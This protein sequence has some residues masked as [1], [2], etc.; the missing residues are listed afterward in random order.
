MRD[1]A[2]LNGP[3]REFIVFSMLEVTDKSLRARRS[4]PCCRHRDGPDQSAVSS[5]GPQSHHWSDSS[6]P[7]LP[8]PAGE[9]SFL[10]LEE[11]HRPK[12]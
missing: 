3:P 1:L 2:Y 9:V 10:P 7:R 11:V 12:P 5:A 4:V 6:L 8:Q